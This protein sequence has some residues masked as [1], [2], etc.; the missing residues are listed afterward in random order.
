MV[1]A[2]REG[3]EIELDMPLKKL[4]ADALAKNRKKVAKA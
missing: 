3:F 1:E 4:E 2:A